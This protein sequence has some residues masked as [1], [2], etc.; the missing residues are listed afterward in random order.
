MIERIALFGEAQNLVGVVTQPGVDAG[1]ERDLA[2]VLLNA[3]V[4][5]RIG[6]GRLN[7]KLARRLATSGF[8]SLR[9]DLSG[10]GDSRTSQSLRSFEAQAVADIRAA[11]DHMQATRAMCRFVLVGLCS[12]ADNGYA[13]AL[14]DQRVVGLVM[15]DPNPY[16]TW[17][18][19]WRFLLMRLGRRRWLAGFL[20]RRIRRML[21]WLRRPSEDVAAQPQIADPSG[22]ERYVRPK[23]PLEEFAAGLGSVLDRGGAVIAVYSGSSLRQF[24]D[25]RQ[26]DEALRPFGLAGRI[27]CRL[28]A[29]A[30]HTFTEL[31]AQIKL[32]DT[33]VAWALEL[34]ARSGVSESPV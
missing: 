3:G 33:V 21:G 19:R 29:Q 10:I 23:P 30:N 17:K 14:A 28:W 4:I 26:L 1:P 18:T 9:L 5:H 16:P 11:M 13:T 6:P 34:A 32:V 20:R 2:F 27:G 15:L 12:G 25:P 24:N 7:V 22:P 31:P 8:T